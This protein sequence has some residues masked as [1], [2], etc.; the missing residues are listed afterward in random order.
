[1]TES[2]SSKDPRP[3]GA[4]RHRLA[5]HFASRWIGVLESLGLKS[6]LE[7]GLRYTRSG[8]VLRLEI[9]PGRVEALVQG[10]RYE[11]YRVRFRVKKLTDRQWDRAIES[12]ASKAVYVAKLLAGEMPTDIEDAFVAVGLTLFPSSKR[13]IGTRCSCPELQN[14]CKHSAAVHF[15]LADQ[16]DQEPFLLFHLRG[17]DREQ[18]LRAL[19][20]R[21]AA[22][23]TGQQMIPDKA[24]PLIGAVDHFWVAGEGLDSIS[25][26]VGPPAVSASLLKRLGVPAFWKPHPEIRGALE[27]LYDK[28]TERSMA[29]AYGGQAAGSTKAKKRR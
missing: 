23:A 29:L 26:S 27:R 25:V 2:S 19:R 17:R 13:E 22:D 3:A 24:G 4:A 20:S 9:E 12:L 16:F 8:R 11:P 10:S 6:R 5:P 15:V 1:M 7:R 28:V 21:R 18:L 14:P